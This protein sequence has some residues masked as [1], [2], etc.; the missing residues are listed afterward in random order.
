MLYIWLTSNTESN[1]GGIRQV[2]TAYTHRENESIPTREKDPQ[3]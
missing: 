2:T 1:N 3:S